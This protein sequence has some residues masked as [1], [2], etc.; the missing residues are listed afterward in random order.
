MQTLELKRKIKQIIFM[1]IIG[2][3]DP[4]TPTSGVTRI[5]LVDGI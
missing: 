4:C 1:P 2:Y 5:S 3:I